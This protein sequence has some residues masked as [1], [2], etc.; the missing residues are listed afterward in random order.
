MDK[1]L[2]H[3]GIYGIILKENSLLAIKKG[4]GPYKDKLDL[5]GGTPLSGE[6]PFETLIRE[7]NEETGIKVLKAQFLGEITFSFPYSDE[8]RHV[9]FVH[10]AQLFKIQNYEI[11]MDRVAAQEDSLGSQWISLSEITPEVVSTLIWESL[12]YIRSM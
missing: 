5:P 10:S 7:V 4:R 12:P 3:K 6:E 1:K 9:P 8:G 11:P 2:L